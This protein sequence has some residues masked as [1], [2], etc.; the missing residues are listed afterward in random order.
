VVEVPVRLGVRD[1]AAEMVEIQSGI[2]AGDTLLLGSA[3]G[4]AP[5]SKVRVLEEEARR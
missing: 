4:I 5:G 1:E 2:A 3:Q